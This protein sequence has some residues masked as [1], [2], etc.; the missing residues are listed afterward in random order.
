VNAHSDKDDKP[1]R[2]RESINRVLEA[3]RRMQA[4]LENCRA[5]GE[6]IVEAARVRARRI[7]QRTEDRIRLLHRRWEEAI[8]A[9]VSAIEAESDG[10]AD[11]AVAGRSADDDF[12]RK[13]V[14]QLAATL[15]TAERDDPGQ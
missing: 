6:E 5:R 12:L 1:A 11:S 8:D 14:A 10:A 7:S 13:A 9:R 4:D 3:E 15:T 2:A